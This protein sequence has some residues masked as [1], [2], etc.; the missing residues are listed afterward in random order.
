MHKWI[1]AA[2]A[3]VALAA[4]A[5]AFGSS[6]R[7]VFGSNRADGQRELYVVNADGSGEHRITF[8]GDAVVER[9]ASFSP[10]GARIAFAGLVAGN[11]DIYTIAADGGDLRRLTT[12][13]AV[14]DWPRWTTDGAIVFGR[15]P[16][17]LTNPLWIVNA[18]GTG[19][20]PLGVGRGLFAEP[21]PHGQ[22]IVF[23]RCDSGTCQLFVS[24]LNGRGTKQI[25]N[26]TATG[27]GSGDFSA[28]WSP[29]GNDLVFTRDT[30][31]IDNDVYVVHADGT[32]L[33]RLTNTPDRVEFQPAWSADGTEVVF[34]ANGR[35]RAV[36]V[37]DG[38]ERAV[39]TWPRAPLADDFSDGIR[40]AS[41][42]HQISDPGGSIVEAGGRLVASISGSAVPGGPFNQVDEHIGSQCSLP[43]D[44]DYQVDYQLLTWPQHG[45]FF[46]A[47]NAF[48]GDGAVARVSTA[49][50]PP[51]DQSYNAWRG[52]ADFLFGQVN[53][54][55][56]SGS[57]RLVR[58][59]GTMSAYV[60]S[61]GSDWSLLFTAP[62][63]TGTT[64]YGMG[65][66]A[67]ASSFGH[68]DGTVAY[69]NFRLNSGE[70]S[71]PDWWQDFSPDVD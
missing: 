37:A 26:V 2:A 22:R 8:D 62:D 59:N 23:S 52:G 14:D 31:G 20:E 45:G 11:W 69:D 6:G 61:P 66:S 44:F 25:S 35:L 19:A 32:D 16:L 10:D 71:C 48:F 34:S 56:M 39:N 63:V 30:N 15:G 46:A 13:P 49:F 12:D 50:D 1:A 53:T 5:P 33:R 67:Q 60:R 64:V 68:Q 54:T 21:A 47:L 36:S 17:N 28:R 38:T 51:F 42:W 43:G 70:L 9:S 18:D 65:L 7:I 57:M 4:A 40:D 3:V 29:S 41:L 58:M 27:G 55:D 24:Q